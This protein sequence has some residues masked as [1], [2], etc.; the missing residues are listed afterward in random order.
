MIRVETSITEFKINTDLKCI[1]MQM[2][3]GADSTLVAY[4]IAKAIVENNLKTKLKRLT[5]GFGNKPDYFKKAE[6]LQNEITKL[7]GKDVWSD[8]YTVFYPHKKEHS[9]LAQLTY[10]FN[11][12]LIDF[13]IN[14]RTRNPPITELSD[15]T[16]SR[17]IERDNPEPESDKNA[18]AEPFYNL[19]KDVIIQEYFDLGIEDLLFKTCSCDA[20]YVPNL[21]FP[22]NECWWCRERAWAFNKI[23]KTDVSPSS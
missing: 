4:L 18:I 6:Q 12:N 1:G 21:I 9:T 14:G 20:N 19:T 3:G 8:P 13:T 10:L 2:S 11:N 17:V 22:C 5:F 15:L 23:G 7:I 16:N